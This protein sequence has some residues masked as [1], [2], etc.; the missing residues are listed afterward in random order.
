MEEILSDRGEGVKSSGDSVGVDVV[1]F[2]RN[3][4]DNVLLHIPR[5]DVLQHG[6]KYQQNMFVPVKDR[7]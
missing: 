6:H 2:S 4:C 1:A 7:T 3:R 5:E